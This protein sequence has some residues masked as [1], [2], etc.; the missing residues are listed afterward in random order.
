M[1]KFGGGSEIILI[2]FAISKIISNFAVNLSARD[3]RRMKM[4]SDFS[5]AVKEKWQVK[6]LLS[7]SDINCKLVVELGDSSL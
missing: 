3:N 5:Q 6:K 1:V 2:C 4:E 7:N